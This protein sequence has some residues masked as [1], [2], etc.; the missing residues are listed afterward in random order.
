MNIGPTNQAG[1]RDATE[2]VGGEDLAEET[3]RVTSGE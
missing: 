1:H 2:L 3:Q